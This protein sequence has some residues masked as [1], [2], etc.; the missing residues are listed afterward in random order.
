MNPQ[1]RAL[2]DKATTFLLLSSGI[3]GN[4]PDP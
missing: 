2:I 3:G 4:R 1:R